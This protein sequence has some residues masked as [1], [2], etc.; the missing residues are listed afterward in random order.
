MSDLLR[1]SRTRRP[2]RMTTLIRLGQLGLLFAVLVAVAWPWPISA[3]AGEAESTWSELQAVSAG[4]E[5]V[6]G[7]DRNSRYTVDTVGRFDF[8]DSLENWFIVTPD[9]MSYWFLAPPDTCD[10]FVAASELIDTPTELLW[11]S[12]GDTGVMSCQVVL[13][14]YRDDTCTVKISEEVLYSPEAGIGWSGVNRLEARVYN[15]GSS[16]VAVQIRPNG[17]S[18]EAAYVWAD[19]GTWTTVWLNESKPGAFADVASADIHIVC[20]AEPYSGTVR[21]DRV[22][23]LQVPY[24]GGSELI[25]PVNG[26]STEERQPQLIWA[27]DE[28]ASSYQLEYSTENAFT[29]EA[30]TIETVTDTA[31]MFADSLEL[32]IYYWRVRSVNGHGFASD[33]SNAF[34]FTVAEINDAP[35]FEVLP[36]T[37][38]ANEG[39]SVIFDVVA[40]DADDDP[41]LL[42]ASGLPGDASFADTGDG[43]GRFAWA[44][45]FGSAGEYEVEFAVDDG[46]VTVSDTVVLIIAGIVSVDPEQGTQG[47]TATVT[48]TGVNTTFGAGTTTLVRFVHQDFVFANSANVVSATELTVQVTIDDTAAVGV[49]DVVVLEEPDIGE[50]VVSPGAFEVLAGS[51]LTLSADTLRFTGVQGE[52]NPAN[53]ELVVGSDNEPLAFALDTTGLTWITLSA[54]SGTT[55][56]T[57]DVAVDISGLSVGD[58]TVSI[59]VTSPGALNS[60]QELVVELSVVAAP[61]NLVVDSTDVSFSA[62]EAGANPE[63]KSFLLETDGDP[64]D[65]AI[66]SYDTS[67]IAVTPQAGTTP[68]EIEVAVDITGLADSGYVD[69]LVITSDGAVNS[70]Q[71]V[72]VSLQVDPAPISLVVDS[73]TLNFT[74]TENG[75]DPPAKSFIV[76]T[77][78]DAVAFAITEFDT[79]WISVVPDSGNTEAPVSV[80]ID[81][82]GLD[83]G[84]YTDTLVISS[85]EA[86]VIN[87]PQQVVVS[88]VLVPEAN[89]IVLDPGSVDFAVVDASGDTPSDEVVVLSSADSFG[90]VAEASASWLTVSPDTG[91]SGDTLTLMVD[92]EGLPV[93]SYEDSVAIRSETADN[94]PQWVLVSMD[95]LEDT[96]PLI[97][98]VTPGQGRQ[99]ETVVVTVTG[100]YT[101]FGSGQ[102]TLVEFVG[103]TGSFTGE[104][105]VVSQTELTATVQV[106]AQADVG[107]YDVRVSEAGIGDVTAEDA[108][109][110]LVGSNL[111]IEPGTLTFSAQLEGANPSPRQLVITSDNQPL[112]IEV[113]TPEADWLSV[114]PVSGET[115]DTIVVEVDVVGLGIGSYSA[116][117]LVSS[118]T[119]LNS[120][121]E[122]AVALTVTDTEFECQAMVEPTSGPAP[123]VVQ[124]Q[125]SVAG[126]TAPFSY[127]WDFGNGYF[128]N[129]ADTS[130][131]Y[132]IP[133]D[134]TV[135]LYVTDD[136]GEICSTLVPIDVQVNPVLT[137]RPSVVDFGPSA[138]AA[139][140]TIDNGGSGM[141]PWVIVDYPDWLDVNPSSGTVDD[142]PQTVGLS[143]NRLVLDPGSYTDSLAVV[144]EVDTVWVAIRIDVVLPDDLLEISPTALDLGTASEVEAFTLRNLGSNAV[145]WDVVGAP[146]W[147]DQL[148]PSFGTLGP[149]KSVTMSFAVDRMGMRAGDYS[150][151]VRIE[152]SEGQRL[153]AGVGMTVPLSVLGTGTFG[154]QVT[155]T[156]CVRFNSV[157]ES[158]ELERYFTVD[159]GGPLEWTSSV[160]GDSVTVVCFSPV[161]GDEFAQLEQVRLVVSDSLSDANGISFA[162]LAPA[163]VFVTGAVVWP[164]DANADGVV[165]ERD[166]VPVGKRF[167]DAGPGRFDAGTIWKPQYRLARDEFSSWSPHEAVYADAD[168][169][170][171]IDSADVCA[172]TVNWGLTTE[173]AS[174]RVGGDQRG[175]ESLFGNLSSTSIASLYGIVCGCPDSEGRELLKLMLASQAGEDPVALPDSPR[176]YKN[177]PNPFNPTT[178]IGFYLPR[179]AYVSLKV[180]NLL[181]QEVKTLHDGRTSQG[182]RTVQWDATD[183][184]GNAVS[185]GTYFYVLEVDNDKRLSERML[186]VK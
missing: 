6:L 177:Y 129:V 75:A 51:R 9:S 23:G 49:Y 65:F 76:G 85:D 92:A 174:G 42:T 162:P 88:L 19:T 61:V 73:V 33:Y 139:N 95:V 136:G 148:Q 145:E 126:G 167:G 131:T 171:V 110:V 146:D 89:N 159:G 46:Q 150:G 30:T 130:H 149:G 39:D 63:A 3:A 56:D 163:P 20:D 116:T 96:T 57:I 79:T 36:D 158:A 17:D 22:L 112:D 74:A 4:T 69:T 122:I 154:V 47:E 40:S 144:S 90:F 62:T 143:A 97:T 12:R 120:P 48:V 178:T 176:L 115:G 2:C 117:I 60:P 94:S 7:A 103:A 185:S 25:A 165:D 82:A 24:P 37:V 86:N 180:Y 170:G 101:Q 113:D 5:S 157:V 14:G 45:P 152:T 135:R 43:G 41:L 156:P 102:A 80:S 87:S 77:D 155:D 70:P 28:D 181:G 142:V 123:L 166:I 100:V 111:V 55:E 81:I 118:E 1:I 34:A 68:G 104:V 15:S 106:P 84:D 128:G 147:M 134:Y 121:Q 161:G 160:E 114:A 141:L 83:E 16:R 183:S 173:G 27:S 59:P 133:G 132:F 21:V 26:D 10:E 53:Q 31:F 32:G 175:A 29:P 184:A 78:G 44:V 109:E 52:A 153:S 66:G 125:A 99:G 151:Q 179:P 119:A 64:V 13:D 54:D 8:S 71:Q 108:F 58:Y 35:Q 172:I 18:A 124:F 186:L 127:Y 168:G 137:V 164:G 105:S 98:Q 11:E 138:T 107:L 93:G 91:V 67:W 38:R 72:I 169:S 140:L 182:P 50:T